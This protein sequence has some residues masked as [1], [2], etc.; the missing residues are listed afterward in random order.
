[1]NYTVLI[2]IILS[3][4]ISGCESDCFKTKTEYY[5]IYNDKELKADNQKFR[6]LFTGEVANCYF[7]KDGSRYDTCQYRKDISK[8][9]ASGLQCNKFRK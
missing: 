7:W 6:I 5:F 4:F 2:L 1:M 8:Y 3:I 9:I